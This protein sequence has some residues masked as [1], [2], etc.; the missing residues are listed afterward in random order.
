MLSL[1]VRSHS[2]TPCRSNA[3]VSAKHAGLYP[4]YPESITL[5]NGQNVTWENRAQLIEIETVE[6]EQSVAL[7]GWTQCSAWQQ[8]LA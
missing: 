2:S 4:P 8:R 7:E 3:D 1:K 6:P 5:A